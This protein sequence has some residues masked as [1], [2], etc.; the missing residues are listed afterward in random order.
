MKNFTIYKTDICINYLEEYKLVK[1]RMNSPMRIET[2][3]N[4]EEQDFYHLLVSTDIVELKDGVILWDEYIED[5]GETTRFNQHQITLKD[6]I[7]NYITKYEL[8]QLLEV[9]FYGSE[10]FLLIKN[11]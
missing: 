4:I 5:D 2:T 8:F 9:I 6:Y 1:I 3:F 11:N 7:S 10:V